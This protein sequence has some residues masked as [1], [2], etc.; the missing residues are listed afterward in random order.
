MSIKLQKFE[1]EKEKLNNLPL[2]Y[3][4]ILYNDFPEPD[5]EVEECVSFSEKLNC[6][7]DHT[8]PEKMISKFVDFSKD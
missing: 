1:I 6:Y 3:N 2:F 7:L 8:P 4:Y 5:A